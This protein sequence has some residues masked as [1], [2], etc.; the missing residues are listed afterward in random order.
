METGGSKT[1]KRRWLWIAAIALVLAAA[2]TAALLLLTVRIGGR[3]YRRA[4]LIDAREASLSAADYDAAAAALPGST[5]RWSVP[6]G[7][8][9]LDSFSETL[10]LSSL[11]EED[12][13]LLQY[14]PRL[15]MVDS[16][17]CTDY[18]ALAAAVR[19]LPETEIRWSIPSADGPVNGNAETLIVRAAGY[20]ELRALLPLLPKLKTLD[21]RESTL[22]TGEIDA[23]RAERPTLQILYTVRFW[24]KEVSSDCR[25]LTLE[26]GADGDPAELADALRRLDA[27]TSAD[28]RGAELSADE[29]GELLA[30][31]PAETRYLVPLCGERY[32]K[33]TEEIDLSGVTIDDLD[34]LESAVA[35]LPQ[36]KKLV[37]CDCGIPDE[38]MAALGERHPETRFIWTVHFSVYSLRTD[39][40][41]F[42]ASDLP[43]R[44]FIAPRA[45]SAELSPLRY[46]TDLVALDLGHM[47]FDDLSF[48]EG[49][50]HLKILI[51]VE[52]RFRDISVLGTLEEL[53][54]LEIFNNNITDISPLLNCKKLRHLNV[55]Y[56][57]GYDPA[58]LWE[59]D[60]LERLWYPGN[61]MGKENCAS[62]AA[63]LPN[64]LCYLPSSDPDGSTGGGWRTAEAYYEMRNAFGM[65]YQPGGTGTGKQE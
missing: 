41:V 17:S 18:P 48:L 34:A 55:G 56:T 47:F 36:L 59:M 9:R 23:L 15:K 65:F 22:S 12:V 49:L 52:E 64:T 54:Y 24:G 39:A 27:L 45:T 16:Q 7:G 30:L 33:D 19:F 2:A 63:A 51:I 29:L 1:K 38:E 31:C 42:C 28:L 58:P 43:S 50:R 37:M 10:T 13:A 3:F 11:P 26:T 61:R 53:E 4:E 60:W 5:I 25:A 46:C 62:L 14:F 6:I 35:L 32:D 57:R 8:E 40:T 21:L 20:D 44:G